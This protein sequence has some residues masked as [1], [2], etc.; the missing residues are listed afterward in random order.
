LESDFDDIAASSGGVD[1]AAPCRNG[2]L[3]AIRHGV[4]RVR[5]E[6]PK[7]L[8]HLILVHLD[9]QGSDGQ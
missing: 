6:V 3:P 2:K 8:A 9:H 1:M 5:G 4:K 7:H